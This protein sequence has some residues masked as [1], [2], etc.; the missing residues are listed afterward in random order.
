LIPPFSLLYVNMLH[1]Y[2]M[3]RP[4]PAFVAQLL[5][6]TR[7]ILAWFLA[8]QR[9]DG[10]LS[11]LPGWTFIDT[12]QGVETFPRQDEQGCSSVVT[13]QMIGALQAAAELQ[14]ALGDPALSERYRKQAKLAAD[15]VYRLCWNANLGLLADTP[16]QDS[17]SQHAN[18]TAVLYDVIP[19]SDQAAVMSKVLA[20][21]LGGAG[22]NAPKLAQVSLFYQF[23]LARALE[24]V[25]MADSYCDLLQRWRNMVALGLTTT[26]EYSD[27]SR[28]DTHAWSAHPA[29]DFP[30]IIAGIRPGSPGFATVRIEPSLGKLQ[31]VEASMPHPKGMILTRYDKHAKTTDVSITLPDTLSGTFIWK[32]SSYPLH[33]GEQKFQLP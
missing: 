11:A 6:G 20:E 29:Y 22:N 32:G 12:P 10:L 2:W 28:S 26:P 4:D 33:S 23:Y 27:P 24:H 25:G 14:Q 7:S 15:G 30:T 9:S 13:L 8:Q 5:L 18:L 16:A 17:Y 3:Y 21:S 31:R 19:K 1:D